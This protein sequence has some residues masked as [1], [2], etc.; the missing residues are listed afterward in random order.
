[1]LSRAEQGCAGLSAWPA[2]AGN[3]QQPS[4][5]SL[6]II[7]FA[8]CILFPRVGG[9]GDGHQ[10]KCVRQQSKA[11]LVARLDQRLSRVVAATPELPLLGGCHRRARVHERVGKETDSN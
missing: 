11:Q 9:Q 1:M 8:I 10:P 2:E 3:E 4:D 6:S 5:V 7:K